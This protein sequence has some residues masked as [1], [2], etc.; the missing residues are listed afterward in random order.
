MGSC[1]YAYPAQ[2]AAT[3]AS[4]Q[5]SQAEL[6]AQY[7][8]QQLGLQQGYQQAYNEIRSL[9]MGS[10]MGPGMGG[11]GFGPLG[12]FAYQNPG[13]YVGPSGLGG[14]GGF[15]GPV[16]PGW[17]TPG[18]SNAGWVGPGYSGYPIPSIIGQGF[19]TPFG[20]LSTNDYGAVQ[21]GFV[22]EDEIEERPFKGGRKPKASSNQRIRVY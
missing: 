15:G 11:P 17:A 19:V 5:R 2:T 18:F 16:N 20:T 21:Q 8:A 3:N 6:N 4:I 9:G 13:P 12:G 10:P 7:N 1:R 14:F 22:E